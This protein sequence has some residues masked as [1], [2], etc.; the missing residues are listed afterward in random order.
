MNLKLKRDPSGLY[1]PRPTKGGGAAFFFV[2]DD[3]KASDAEIE[4]AAAL[5]GLLGRFGFIASLPTLQVDRGILAQ[6]TRSALGSLA[7]Q[8]R[9]GWFVAGGGTFRLLHSLLIDKSGVV[10]KIAEKRHLAF[11]RSF[12]LVLTKGLIFSWSQPNTRFEIAN[13]GTG[14]EIV[15]E[16][17]SV[18]TIGNVFVA[19]DGQAAGRFMF[20]LTANDSALETLDIGLRL[21]D[22]ANG[23]AIASVR[24]PLF[25]GSAVIPMNGCIDP[26]DLEIEQSAKGLPGTFF[27]FPKGSVLP[28][29]Y[30]TSHGHT[31]SLVAED[32][33]RLEFCGKVNHSSGTSRNFY[34]TPSGT[35]GVRVSSNGLQNMLA[36]DSGTEYFRIDNGHKLQFKTGGPA[37]V[38]GTQKSGGPFLDTLATTP[39]VTV[40]TGA[41]AHYI[42]QSEDAPVFVQRNP[43]C[44]HD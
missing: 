34:L 11:K 2:F 10:I 19:V 5:T 16:T 44:Q 35:F 12:D 39:W 21:F 38:T 36:G 1:L 30:R 7:Q 8:A 6:K 25:D 15:G 20:G 24:Y 40:A 9:V 14:V 23:L 29:H 32:D 27:S 4:V 43:L 37:L 41:G 31:V 42:V 22:R 3:P 17:A 18:R 33:T 26:L 13:P 28:S